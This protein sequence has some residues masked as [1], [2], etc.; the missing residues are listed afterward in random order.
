MSKLKLS[1]WAYVAE[2][3]TSVV[4]I[5]SLAYVGL[6][7]NQNTQALQN[8]SH[9]SVNKL[10]QDGDI[11]LATN[12]DLHRIVMVA[13]KSP[14]DV[15]AEEWS[16]YTHYMLPRIGIWEYLYLA[17]QEEA[18]SDNQW[19][20]FEPY[21][22]GLVCNRGNARFWEEK[23]SAYAPAFRAYLET[24]VLPECSEQ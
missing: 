14:S 11:A 9:L 18:I 8:A 4:V 12:E 23:Q 7:V 6:E 17:K 22:L 5:V 1:E 2:I 21:Y 19:L 3:L 16:R 13:N 20:A 24:E 15:S 10:L